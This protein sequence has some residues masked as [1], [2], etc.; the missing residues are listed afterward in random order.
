VTAPRSSTLAELHAGVDPAAGV[1]DRRTARRVARAQTELDL[2]Q[3]RVRR[4]AVL[5]VEIAVEVGLRRA[6][7]ALVQA[8]PDGAGIGQAGFDLRFDHPFSPRTIGAGQPR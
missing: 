5:G 7:R 2:G 4:T 8:G 6:D 3:R 1:P